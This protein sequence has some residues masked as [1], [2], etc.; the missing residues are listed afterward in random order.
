MSGFVEIAKI[1]FKYGFF[2][3]ILVLL[4]SI[5]LSLVNLSEIVGFLSPLVDGFNSV[6]NFTYNVLFYWTGG[7]FRYIYV[8]SLSVVIT[9]L[10][11]WSSYGLIQGYKIVV[12]WLMK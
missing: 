11:F 4:G 6:I 9:K 12:E 3:A 5:V 1:V 10:V 2:L 8:A 7:A